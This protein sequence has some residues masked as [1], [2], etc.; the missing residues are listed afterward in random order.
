VGGCL[1]RLV[2]LVVLLFVALVGALFY[3]GQVLL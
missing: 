3:F 1:M 2:L